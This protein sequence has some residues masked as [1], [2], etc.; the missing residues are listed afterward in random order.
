MQ[1]AVVT[2]ITIVVCMCIT[3]LAGSMAYLNITQ[4]WTY[5]KMRKIPE[6]ALEFFVESKPPANG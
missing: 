3:G 5:Q 1:R 4:P 2:P 6:A